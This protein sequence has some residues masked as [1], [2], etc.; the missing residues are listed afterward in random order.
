[1]KSNISKILYFGQPEIRRAPDIE[2]KKPPCDYESQEELD[3]L[4]KGLKQ[5]NPDCLIEYVNVSKSSNEL[6]EKYDIIDSHVWIIEY[7]DMT[8][9]KCDD[10]IEFRKEIYDL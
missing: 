5:N 4:L 7:N 9:K 2:S 6:I 1:M 3:I 8:L 10:D